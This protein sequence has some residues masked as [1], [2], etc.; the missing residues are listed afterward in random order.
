MESSEEQVLAARYVLGAVLGEGGMGIVR[1]A[2][3]LKLQR[4]VA[5]KLLSSPTHD[6]GAVRRF[7]GEALAAGS[8]QHANVV[9]VFDAGEEHGRPFL[10]TE[11]LQ[12]ETLRQRL[13]RGPVP[14]EQ[15]QSWA[16]QLLAGLAAAHEKGLIHRDLKPSNLFITKDGWLKILDFGLA[17]LTGSDAGR[18]VGTIGYMAPE[19]VRGLPV[20]QRA[21]LFNF[22]LVL[23]EMLTGK[24]AFAD[25]SAT[26]TSYAII[27]REP[28][29]L[30][31][32]VPASLRRLIERCLS[33]D[34]EQRPASAK[35]IARLLQA[36]APSKRRWLPA[37]VLLLI[38]L[39][40]LARDYLIEGAPPPGSVSVAP[41]DG[42]EAPHFAALADGTSELL[43]IDLRE[44]PLRS[45]PPELLRQPVKRDAVGN[46]DRARAAAL[47]FH[48]NYFIFGNV[49]E[50][51][52]ELLV[53]ATLRDTESGK[54]L[55]SAS[56]QDK[57]ENLLRLVRRL[58][59]RLQRRTLPGKAFDARLALLQKALTPAFPALQAWFESQLAWKSGHYE[60][61]LAALRRAIGIDPEFAQANYM[62]AILDF[63]IRPDSA[64]TELRAALRHEDSLTA[65]QRVRARFQLLRLQGDIAEAE[66]LLLEAMREHPEN[67]YFPAYMGEY[68][69]DRATLLGRPPYTAQPWFQRALEFEP[70][71]YW[72]MH[73]LQV[74]GM[75]RGERD[76]VAKLSDRLLTLSDSPARKAYY[77]LSRAW[78]RDDQ[79]EHDEVLKELLAPGVPKLTLAA[80]LNLSMLK[81]DGTTDVET[82]GELMTPPLPVDALVSR[83]MADL[84]HGRVK[85]ARRDL[86]AITS[87]GLAIRTNPADDSAYYV[88]WIDSL[89]FFKATPAE[90]AHSRAA[91]ARLD[92]SADPAREPAKQHL[93]GRL[94][95]RAKDLEGA[96]AAIAAL[97]AMPELPK[98]TIVADLA[99]ELKAR[100]LLASGDPAAAL[101]T[102]E[103]Q[104][105]RVP[106]RLA[107]FYSRADQSFFHASLLVAVGRPREALPLYDAVSNS[108]SDPAFFAPG[109]LYLGRVHDSLGDKERAIFHY[110][111]F[112]SM[113]TNADPEQ[114]PEVDRA[115][116][117]L[118]ELRATH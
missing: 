32:S 49:R 1:K 76:V 106:E 21:D 41:F 77:R 109:N 73:N 20:D 9:Q 81:M 50:R 67:A 88:P 64:E 23:Y 86:A 31:A 46:P 56:A 39:A 103:Q 110:A 83:G 13:A 82:F 100:I 35:E 118:A 95:L 8:L 51:Q 70:E 68:I 25:I 36:R 93:I 97:Q 92:V 117:R 59:D 44:A 4:E 47:Q 33:K 48:A 15:A 105:I 2:L 62:L 101:A 18:V 42:R 94:A 65:T 85:A 26:E 40:V 17:K 104:K 71:N 57:P 98:S 29:P 111:R 60:D 37:L 75:M 87:G 22:G 30:P 96:K 43:T 107:E 6:A 112:V 116:K 102:F 45:I 19:Q 5:V 113:W 89:D 91:A 10:V 12:G 28:E 7:S 53:E 72:A 74:L 63:E 3:D 114:R 66:Q 61:R 11:L 52:G 90:L 16:R 34:R 69:E 115:Q 58:S 108:V 54:V 99:L 80:M 14:L 78:A 79:A 38:P 27:V 55:V 84:F 24:R